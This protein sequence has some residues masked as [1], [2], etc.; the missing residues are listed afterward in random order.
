MI[1]VP[2]LIL[3]SLVTVGVAWRPLGRIVGSQRRRASVVLGLGSALGIALL[4]WGTVFQP[5][6][7]FSPVP[8]APPLPQHA[9]YW[10]L[11]TGSRIAY[12]KVPAMGT[13]HATPII[14]VHGG[15]G[16]FQVTSADSRKYFA[17]YARYGYDVYLY[18]QVGSG[19]SA[20]LSDVSQYTVARQVA[21]LEA[22]R[23]TIGARHIILMGVSWGGSLI[24]NYMAAHP[25]QVARAVL[26][27]P[28]A[29]NY[30]EWKGPIN[31]M[32]DRLAPQQRAK[33]DTVFA[34]K[35]LMAW[36][37]L[38][39]I[40]P[41][42]AANLVSNAELDR[43]FDSTYGIW[44]SALTCD[45]AHAPRAGAVNGFGLAVSM[46]TE[47][48]PAMRYAHPRTQ[49]GTNRTPVL[50][51]T[52]P[53]N[54]IPWAVTYQYRTTLPNSKLVIV[55]GAGHVVY[56]DRPRLYFSLVRAFLFNKPLPLKPYTGA[57][58]P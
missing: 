48:D 51:V 52:G 23:Q 41:G 55:P 7:P 47:S 35:R 58:Q 28:S 22:I 32:S 37:F 11:S 5:L 26:T 30:A 14:V 57:G 15:P 46:M 31:T 21:D 27:S 43:Y 45:A 40:S 50:I 4:G 34:Q 36:F 9:G 2:S 33:W 53:C 39:K 6:T 10:N 12:L 18:D 29:I 56:Y 24:A 54:Y 19:L 49:L 1:V 17:P 38:A 3:S 13:R 25:T 44:S 42:A 8:P 20:R 16:A